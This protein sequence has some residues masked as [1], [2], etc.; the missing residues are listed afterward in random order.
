MSRPHL[1]LWLLAALALSTPGCT[2]ITALGEEPEDKPDP[3]EMSVVLDMS[4]DMMEPSVFN[5]YTSCARS[6]AP[7]LVCVQALDAQGQQLTEFRCVS[8]DEVATDCIEI[9]R[10]GGFSMGDLTTLDVNNLPLL[11]AARTPAGVAAFTRDPDAAHAVVFGDPLTRV[12]RLAEGSMPLDRLPMGTLPNGIWPEALIPLGP[13]AT[14]LLLLGRDAAGSGAASSIWYGVR[15]NTGATDVRPVRAVTWTHAS[16]QRFCGSPGANFGAFYDLPPQQQGALRLAGLFCSTDR[17][18]RPPEYVLEGVDN[19]Q[20]AD[21]DAD[22]LELSH[23]ASSPLTEQWTSEG[24]ALRRVADVQRALD[25]NVPVV[26]GLLRD[27]SPDDQPGTGGWRIAQWSLPPD[28]GGWEQRSGNTIDLQGLVAQRL[29]NADCGM[30][31]QLLDGRAFL[32]VSFDGKLLQAALP[33]QR[34]TDT[35]RWAVATIDLSKATS[36]MMGCPDNLPSCRSYEPAVAVR[37][38]DNQSPRLLVDMLPGPT[39]GI[40][41]SV[42]LAGNLPSAVRV[43]AFDGMMRSNPAV[44]RSMLPLNAQSEGV[45]YMP[46]RLVAGPVRHHLIGRRL[47]IGPRSSYDLFS[48]P[49]S[50]QGVPLCPAPMP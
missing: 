9:A 46:A 27:E 29:R 45:L 48:L 38:L 17:F 18:N 20:L 19:I 35:S 50:R 33:Y 41:T 36:S 42:D 31:A 2:L 44:L 47:T 26:W 22:V 49:L 40:D 43:T 8:P 21:A 6:C 28:S 30:D 4:S 23:S 12:F 15:L 34:G 32:R 39:S 10:L 11:L 5:T 24:R 16:D 37:C 7:D 14:A 25:G 13:D 3:A 1:S